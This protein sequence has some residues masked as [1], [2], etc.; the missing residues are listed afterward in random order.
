MNLPSWKIFLVGVAVA[1]ALG[2]AACSTTPTPTVPPPT[3]AP[4]PQAAAANPLPYSLKD[5][6]QTQIYR[7]RVDPAQTTAEYAVREVLLGNDQITRG[8]TSAVDGEFQLYMQNGKVYIALSN[9]QVDLSTLTS[10]SPIRDEAIRKQWLESEKYPKAIFVAN[11]VQGLPLDAVQGQPY[12]FQV[13]GNLTIRN[14]SQPATFDVTVTAHPNSIDGQGTTIIHMKD[15]G[16]DPPSVAGQTIVS[17]PATI[18][19]KGVANLIEG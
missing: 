12:N 6:K 2:L 1:V 18:T 11:D 7:F 15:F 13:S 10:D 16:F 3:T 17:D 9:L 5:I 19:I 14:I 4:V 8:K